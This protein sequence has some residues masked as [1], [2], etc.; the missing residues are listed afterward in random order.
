LVI[1]LRSGS[2]SEQAADAFGLLSIC[3]F[4]GLYALYLSWE[5]RG[6]STPTFN[7]ALAAASCPDCGG[8]PKSYREVG[9]FYRRWL[10]RCDRCNR[11]WRLNLPAN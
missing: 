6:N 9:I 10:C 4:L 11:E 7:D 5:P 3:A 1:F 2:I 8:R